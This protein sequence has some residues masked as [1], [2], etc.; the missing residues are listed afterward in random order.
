MPVKHS[1][2]A[3]QTRSQDKAQALLTPT[4][5]A[6]LDSTPADPQGPVS[7]LLVKNSVEEEEYDGT[8]SVPAPMGESQ[9]N[10]GPTIAQSNKPVSHQ[11]KQFLLAIMQQMTQIRANIQEASSSAASR[12]P[13]FKTPSMKPPKCFDRTQPLKVTSFIQSC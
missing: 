4:Q 2:P 3:K 6:P 10:G 1:S 11:S 7:K 5:R 12:P 8:E 13:A 9:G